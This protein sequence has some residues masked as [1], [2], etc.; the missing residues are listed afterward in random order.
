MDQTKLKQIDQIKKELEAGRVVDSVYAFDMHHI[1][2]LA[3]IIHRLKA[4]GLPI[5]AQRRPGSSLAFYKL[6]DNW[7]QLLKTE[8]AQLP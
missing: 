1:T 5:E 6:P 2:R 4:R 7:Q 3:S 8:K